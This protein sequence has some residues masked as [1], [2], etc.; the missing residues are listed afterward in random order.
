MAAAAGWVEG[1]SALIPTETLRDRG[2]LVELAVNVVS[3]NPRQP[4]TI[5]T[6]TPLPP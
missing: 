6:R 3:P 4:A 2:A 1:L 5:S